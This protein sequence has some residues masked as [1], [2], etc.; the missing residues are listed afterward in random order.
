MT[1]L[2]YG[3][4]NE[5]RYLHVSTNYNGLKWILKELFNF[6]FQTGK[7]E[8]SA[9]YVYWHLWGLI[10]EKP[11]SFFSDLDNPLPQE[12]MYYQQGCGSESGCFGR[13]RIWFLN[14]F[15]NVQFKF[16]IYFL[17]QAKKEVKGYLNLKEKLLLTH[18]L[19]HFSS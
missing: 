11:P 4:E 14:I 5:T 6:H 2:M 19:L 1:N 13:I 18:S 12:M 9:V 3:V 10:D 8:L 17:I 16:N 7:I 15:T